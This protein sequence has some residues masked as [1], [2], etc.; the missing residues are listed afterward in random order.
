ML[1]ETLHAVG[2][3]ILLMKVVPHLD[4]TYVILLMPLIAFVPGVVNLHA[5]IASF[6][7]QNGQN[8]QVKFGHGLWSVFA[9][10]RT[11]N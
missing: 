11:I 10:V 5:K 6:S 9:L 1:W 8:G 2:E 4:S 7:K 3:A